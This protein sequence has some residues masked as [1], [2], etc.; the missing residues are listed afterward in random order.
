MLCTRPV[1]F[2][3]RAE[4]VGHLGGFALIVIDASRTAHG[5][6]PSG[7]LEP[8]ERPANG[9]RRARGAP[10]ARPSRSNTTSASGWADGYRRV[11]ASAGTALIRRHRR[12]MP[13]ASIA[14]SSCSAWCSRRCAVGSIRK[15]RPSP[16]ASVGAGHGQRPWLL[17]PMLRFEH[18]LEADCTAGQP[19]G[20]VTTE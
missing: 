16:W 7:A 4:S 20:S 11:T 9:L 13:S 15:R 8:T 10:T 6:T 1:H 17:G 3:P 19:N 2:L 5:S 18:A 12:A 14:R